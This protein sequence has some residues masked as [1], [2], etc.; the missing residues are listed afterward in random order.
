M[1]ID[2]IRLI[3]TDYNVYPTQP[4][5]CA[6]VI[7]RVFD[8][9]E[10]ANE[11][12]ERGRCEAES[13]SYI[14]GASNQPTKAVNALMDYRNHRSINQVIEDLHD[15]WRQTITSSNH[16]DQFEPGQKKAEQLEPEFREDLKRWYE[17]GRKV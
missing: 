17:T 16:P 15:G 13:N 12:T 6:A 14:P 1:T 11:L 2:E 4:L 8:T 7:I 10:A 5:V 3:N 9:P